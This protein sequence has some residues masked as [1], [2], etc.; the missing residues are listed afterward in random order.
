MSVPYLAQFY[1]GALLL[2]VRSSR[3]YFTWAAADLIDKQYTQL[4][5]PWSLFTRL[6]APYGKWSSLIHGIDNHVYTNPESAD[7]QVS[8]LIYPFSI[9]GIRQHTV[10][11]RTD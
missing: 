4:T 3:I 8:H 11:W 9:G 6:P 2:T 10:H 7:A 1:C 5:V